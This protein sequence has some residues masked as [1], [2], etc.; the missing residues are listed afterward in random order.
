[1][2]RGRLIAA[3][4]V[5]G[6]TILAGQLPGASAGTPGTTSVVAVDEVAGRPVY[7]VKA[8]SG[9]VNSITAS[10]FDTGG[11]DFDYLFTDSGAV[12]VHPTADALC[13]QVGDD[14]QCSDPARYLLVQ[15]ADG[16]DR[17]ELTLNPAAGNLQGVEAVVEGGGGQD[18]VL[19]GEMNQQIEGGGGGD[20][21][22]GGGDPDSII[23]DG[24]KDKL[25]GEGGFDTLDARD[26][27]ADRRIDCGDGANSAEEAFV[28]NKDPKPISC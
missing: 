21:L 9:A 17:V 4:A 18:K 10:R 8:V 20:V 23:G 16:D 14:V 22:R 11:G 2:R 13:D 3:L 5:L 7:V 15:A 28:D 26:G 12:Q 24:G 25:F 6:G 27:K 1:V 19:G